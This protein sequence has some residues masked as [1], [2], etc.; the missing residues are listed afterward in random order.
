MEYHVGDGVEVEL[1]HVGGQG[2]LPLADHAR[3]LERQVALVVQIGFE[4]AAVD[5]RRAGD[6]GLNG[7][8]VRAQVL[9]IGIAGSLDLRARAN[10]AVLQ[11]ERAIH[12]GVGTGDARDGDGDGLDAAEVVARAVQVEEFFGQG[13]DA[14]AGGAQLDRAPAEPPEAG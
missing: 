11:R 8:V 3:V 6:D 2:Q 5:L 14:G 13:D 4:Q 12:A 7:A 1:R 10:G 9:G